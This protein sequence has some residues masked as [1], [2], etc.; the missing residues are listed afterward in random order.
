MAKAVKD[1]GGT[2]KVTIMP[3]EGRKPDIGSFVIVVKGRTIVE[4]RAMKRPFLTMKALNM[5][6]VKAEVLAALN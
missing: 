2:V 3:A 4:C 6:D 1:A 5:D